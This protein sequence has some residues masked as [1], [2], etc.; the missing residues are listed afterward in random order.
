MQLIQSKFQFNLTPVR[1]RQLAVLITAVLMVVALWWLA[2]LTWRVVTPASSSVLVAPNQSVSAAAQTVNVRALQALHVFG[3]R[4]APENLAPHDLDAPETTLN[5]RLV[6]LVASDR[7]ELSA[8]IIEQGGNQRTYI[9]GER[10]SNSRASVEQIL[11]DRVLLD[12]GGRRE[13]LY[14]EGHDGQETALR[15]L[16]P[17]SNSNARP[18]TSSASTV[19]VTLSDNDALAANLSSVRD[20]PSAILEIISITPL[21]EDVPGQGQQVVGYRLVPREDTELFAALGLQPGDIA[22][23]INGFDLTDPS[24]ALAAMNEL[25]DASRAI[26]QVRRNNELVDLELQVQ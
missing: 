16:P 2:Q 11:A 22:L 18:D 24:Q 5:V 6:G 9:I 3:D 23:Q 13:V 8:A 12:N 25:E 20:D 15:M 1:Q 21:R 26:I 4:A 17:T 14:I 7:A 19:Q 10:I